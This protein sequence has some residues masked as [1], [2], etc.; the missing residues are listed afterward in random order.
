MKTRIRAAG[1]A[2]E[3]GSILL[4]KHS[5]DGD[6]VWIPPGGRVEGAETFEECVIRETREETGLAAT[7]DR[8]AYMRESYQTSSGTHHFELFFRAN[9]D[10]LN[11]VKG[12]DPEMGPDDQQI[13]AVEWISKDDLLGGFPDRVAP[14]IIRTPGFW[15]QAALGF[16]NP[17]YID[18]QIEATE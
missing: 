11:A 14:D 10:S 2:I 5:F 13:V 4:V 15:H 7:V 16:S 12:S 17:G 18:F 6:E 8:L 1:L 9:V 3:N